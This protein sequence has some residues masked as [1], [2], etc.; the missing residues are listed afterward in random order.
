VEDVR[1]FVDDEVVERF[2][3]RDE[4]LRRDVA[5]GF[6]A[7]ADETWRVLS[8]QLRTNARE[9]QVPEN[10][11]WYGFRDVICVAPAVGIRPATYSI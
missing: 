2:V 5:G 10:A 8:E 11:P 9:V 1:R 7:Q 6:F 3:L 4:V